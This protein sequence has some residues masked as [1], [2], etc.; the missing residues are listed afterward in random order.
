MKWANSHSVVCRCKQLELANLIALKSFCIENNY[1]LQLNIF[2][3]FNQYQSVIARLKFVD[4]LLSHTGIF[5]RAFS[6]CLYISAVLNG[7]DAYTSQSIVAVNV[8]VYFIKCKRPSS[9]PFDSFFFI[10][11][12]IYST[13]SKVAEEISSVVKMAIQLFCCLVSTF[14]E[15]A[16]NIIGLWKL[17]RIN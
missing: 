14:N 4:R 12:Q 11:Y 16:A 5:S 13:I 9:W 6:T 2:V 7:N 3:V 15:N 1:V 8:L 17:S 10:I